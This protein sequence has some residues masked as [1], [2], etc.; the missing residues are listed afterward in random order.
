MILKLKA[1]F[2]NLDKDTNIVNVYDL[3]TNGSFK[4]RKRAEQSDDH[5]TTL[6]KLQE[7]LARIPL[8]EDIVLLGDFNARTGML[9]D[10][11]PYDDI[12]EHEDINGIDKYGE[13]LPKRNNMDAKLNAN[14][15]PF[16]ELLQTMDLR[17]L[18]GRTLG[19]IFG[20]PTCIQ[21][22][23]VSTV[24][25]IC[26]SPRLFSKVRQ[27][28]V[29]GISL[30]PDHRPLSMTISTDPIRRI[31]TSL[32]STD[33]LEAPK[34]YKWSR[35]TIPHL[36]TSFN[37]LAAQHNKTTIDRINQLLNREVNT[38]CEL[39]EFNKDVVATYTQMADT[40]TTTKNGKRT[41]KKKWFDWSCRIA[42]R[43]VS[44]AERRVDSDP[45]NNSL[46]EEFFLRKKEYRTTKRTKK[47]KFLYDMN[48][49]INNSGK[50][51]WS[52]LKQL[53]EQYKDEEPF[54]V[55]DLLLFHKFFNDLYN[56]RCD[57]NLHIDQRT[58]LCPDKTYGD[59]Q[60]A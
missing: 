58:N 54:D 29:G 20:E 16:I 17:I 11:L 9:A 4:K 42:K 34:P 41:N 37:F 7:I 59:L 8:S 23:G 21:R 60:Q 50:V 49:K 18:N 38:V 2:F 46:R 30:F 3:P 56:R 55:Y 31:A 33:I 25:Y 44:Q 13:P 6:E 40:V 47:G 24:D 36:D 57:K 22:Q 27:F 26:V 5:S 45:T 28:T 10:S 14:G 12:H 19:D 1:T 52:A 43:K 35:S 15:R 39:L 48:A 32:T 53:S 51:D